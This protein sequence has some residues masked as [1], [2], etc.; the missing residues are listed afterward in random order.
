[1]KKSACDY[2]DET[3]SRQ[4]NQKNKLVRE[5]MSSPP[6]P[7][8]RTFSC[9]SNIYVQKVGLLKLSNI[10]IKGRTSL[11]YLTFESSSGALESPS[12]RRLRCKHKE[13][14]LTHRD[15]VLI[16]LKRGTGSLCS[17]HGK[18]FCTE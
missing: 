4:S 15:Y 14:I 3:K 7:H 18:T 12:L 6:L 8:T 16:Y 17:H 13:H 9:Y 11:R 5:R 10:D 1:M 2:K